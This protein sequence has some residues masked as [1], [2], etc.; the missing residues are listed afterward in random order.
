M[1]N[2]GKDKDPCSSTVITMT[3]NSSTNSNNTNAN[4]NTR[5]E[6]QRSCGGYAGTSGIG[7]PPGPYRGPSTESQQSRVSLRVPGS[8]TATPLLG[9]KNNNSATPSRTGTSIVHQLTHQYSDSTTGGTRSD[10]N[11]PIHPSKRE[12]FKWSGVIVS[13]DADSVKIENDVNGAPPG[14]KTIGKEVHFIHT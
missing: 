6:R 9:H 2:K 1:D 11:L 14:I 3:T 8:L 5:L 13:F 10:N 4:T 7:Q 12:K